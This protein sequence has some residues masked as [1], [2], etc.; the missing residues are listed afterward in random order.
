MRRRTFL[1]VLAG[2]ASVLSIGPA[3]RALRASRAGPGVVVGEAR[4]GEGLVQRV[5]SVSGGFDEAI[6][7]QLLGAANVFKEGDAIVG[8]AAAD[9]RSRGNARALL[10][11]TRPGEVDAHPLLRDSL[12]D[13]LRTDVDDEAARATAGMTFGA[14]KRFLLER[15][16]DE[17]KAIMPG[18][19]SEV[20]GCVVKLMSDRELVAVGSKIFNPLPGSRIG[21]KGY[22]G[23]RIQPNSP[24]DDVD[25][26]RWQVFSGWSF[27]VGDVVLGNNPVSSRPESVL[28]IQEALKDLLDTFGLD[29]VLPHCVLSHIDV[30]AEVER[31]RPGST[32]LWF[33]SIAGSDS[34][35]RTFGVDT[36]SMCAYA[37]SRTGPFGLYFETG[38]GADFTNGH[39]HGFDM[40]LHE[41][42]KYG[43]A[44]ALSR[45]VAAAR[46]GAGATDPRPWVHLNDVAG[47]I[48]PEVFRTREQLVRCC[49]EDIVM[50]K[51]HGL[52]I[53]L[54]VC[55]TLHM[56]VSLDD[57][58]WCLDRIL[59]A[60]PAYL[61]ALPTKIDPMLGYLTTGF[62]DHVRLRE[63]FGYKVDDR[64]W[65][66][67]RR[68]G[69]IDA[70]GRPTEHF[71]D[72]I[73][74]YR[75]YRRLKGDP[76][77]DE[78]I[79]SEGE[80]RIDQVRGHG[81]FLARGRGDRPWDPEPGLG[82]AV[83][84]IYDDAKRS[85]WAELP[86]GFV[87]QVPGVVR[88]ETRSADRSD[89]IVHPESGE[90]LSARGAE[91]IRGLRGR[92]RGRFDVQV[93]VS[94]GLNALAITD[95]GHLG[96]FLDRLR[97]RLD[98]EGY[99]PAPETIVVTSGRV[100]AGYR[101]GEALFGGLEGPRAILH[102]IG[103]RPGTGHHTFSV[104]ITSPPGPTWAEEGRVDHDI[105]R[106]ASGIAAT[107]MTPVRGADE[108]VDL[109]NTLTRAGR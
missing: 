54:D 99:R 12:T 82:E 37:S 74:V 33:Q 80:A 107:A 51:L 36:E 76:R 58:D 28:A 79:A 40:V 21:A 57:L 10:A 91:A 24:T 30:Q 6:F 47:F 11:N 83:R 20:I 100:R 105:T 25:D 29:G 26:V 7:K 41:S 1:G 42:R 45:L 94:D 39:G 14:L 16:E 4:A 90:R 70:Q 56:D 13:L 96:P 55:S 103:E 62:Q 75:E 46:E 43:F 23:A 68:L 81:V 78:E 2:G 48:G 102:V 59:P 31:L 53:G 52:C 89:Y 71:G 73:H 101:I 64:M 44:R 60:N 19:S 15:D 93:V 18:L 65:G 72:P 34:A 98:A 32:A 61:M 97:E 95:E 88:V 67:F 35:N 22:L 87:E 27:A 66:F 5:H 69:V 63:R 85:I 86:P 109:L 9:E 38:Q 50:G 49:L 106:V 77:S 17:I 84:R 104:Y 108:A 8:V 92:H 3:G